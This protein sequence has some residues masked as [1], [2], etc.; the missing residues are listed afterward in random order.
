MCNTYIRD[1]FNTS[2]HYHM[3]RRPSLLLVLP[4]LAFLFTFLGAMF[5][6]NGMASLG[7]GLLLSGLI[8]WIGFLYKAIVLLLVK[9]DQVDGD[10]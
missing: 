5:K 6:I 10:S 1:A 2:R 4:V 3:K 9:T 7:N 8:A